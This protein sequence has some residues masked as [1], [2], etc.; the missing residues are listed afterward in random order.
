MQNEIIDPLPHNLVGMM[1]DQRLKI[2]KLRAVQ[3]AATANRQVNYIH[4]APVANNQ[5]GAGFTPLVLA[6]H[7][8]RLVFVRIE[9]HDDSQIF[10]QLGH[11][12]AW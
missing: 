1:P 2:L 5:F 6:V 4:N 8:D 10:V 11:T 3:R 12:L 9:Q 7:V